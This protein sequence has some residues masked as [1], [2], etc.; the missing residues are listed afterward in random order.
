M[1]R[2]LAKPLSYSSHFSGVGTVE[3][4]MAMLASWAPRVAH[5]DFEACTASMCEI[6]PKCQKVLSERARG[7]HIFRDILDRLNAPLRSDIAN[8]VI[9]GRLDYAR[10]R[11]AVMGANMSGSGHC[12]AHGGQCPFPRASLDVS[13]TPCTPWSRCNKSKNVRHNHPAALLML[14]WCATIR[15]T[16]PRV[17][18]HE[19][20][21]GFDTQSLVDL[22]G[23]IYSLHVLRVRPE[24]MGFPFIRR[25]RVYVILYLK[26]QMRVAVDPARFYAAVVERMSFGDIPGSTDWIWRATVHELLAEE[27][28]ARARLKL[29]ALV[30]EPRAPGGRAPTNW[31]YLLTQQQRAYLAEYTKCYSAQF[32]RDPALDSSC[33]FDLTQSPKWTRGRCVFGLPTFCRGSHRLWSPSRGRWLTMAEQAAAMGFP[34]YHDLAR[35]AGVPT[36]AATLT[37]PLFAMGNAMHVANVA[38]VMMVALAACA[39]RS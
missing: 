7:C 19:N 17:V 23:D 15:S 24:H 20:V 31:A 16:R 21:E 36:D 14:A 13:G 22:L 37:S 3:V 39:P 18:V 11:P 25:P 30:E 26:S 2:I 5:A 38:C 1:A 9:D 29:G 34:I 10:A 4:A 12:V 27:N 28:G 8:L 32:G 6:S 35:A 33:V